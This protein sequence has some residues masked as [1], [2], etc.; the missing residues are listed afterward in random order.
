MYLVVL[1]GWKQPF[2]PGTQEQCLKLWIQGL[3]AVSY[4]GFD[5]FFHFTLREEYQQ[6]NKKGKKTR[7]YIAM[8]SHQRDKH[9][10]V[11]VPT[12]DYSAVITT[13]HE[14]S[15]LQHVLHPGSCSDQG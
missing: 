7:H 8:G 5:A 4:D 3:R 14:Y 1:A 12:L 10:C 9:Q 6:I 13:L 15:V 2:E 11:D